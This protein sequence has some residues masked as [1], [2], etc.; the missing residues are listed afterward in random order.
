MDIISALFQKV[1]TVAASAVQQIYQSISSSLAPVFT[2]A[3]TIYVAYWGYEMIYGRAPLTAGAF[4]WR[5]IRIGVIYTLAFSWGDF[6][7]IV[8]NVF[9]QGADGVATAVCTAVGGANCGTPETSVSSTLSTLFTNALTA[10]KTVAASGGW[11]PRS[12]SR[13]SRSC[14]SSPRSSSSRS[15]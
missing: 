11:A 10:G 6:S 7:S 1:D 3:L 12:A 2:V 13:C 15:P 14:C 4:M 8:V 5:I 9:T